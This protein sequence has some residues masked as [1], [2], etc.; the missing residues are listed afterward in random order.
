VTEFDQIELRA[1]DQWY[2]LHWRTEAQPVMMPNVLENKILKPQQKI[3][4]L[5]RKIQKKE[6]RTLMDWS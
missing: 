4:A 3:I 6:N 2:S 5:K 1:K